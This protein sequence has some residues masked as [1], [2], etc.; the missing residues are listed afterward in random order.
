[1]FECITLLR[2]LHFAE[3]S[4][5][6]IKFPDFQNEIFEKNEIIGFEQDYPRILNNLFYDKKTRF[7]LNKITKVV[8]AAISG[9]NG[10]F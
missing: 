10:H 3:K 5:F 2:V 4:F 7:K 9:K 1:M 6:Q 8:A